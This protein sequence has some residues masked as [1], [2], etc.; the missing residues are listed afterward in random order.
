M[1]TRPM[2]DGWAEVEAHLIDD[3]GLDPDYVLSLDAEDGRRVHSWAHDHDVYE[4]WHR[5]G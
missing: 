5:H 4:R 3:H 1:T 2:P